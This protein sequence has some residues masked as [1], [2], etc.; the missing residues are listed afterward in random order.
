MT[1]TRYITRPIKWI[2]QP[3]SEPIFCEAA[4]TIEITDEAGGEFVVIAQQTDQHANQRIAVS[5]E[6]WPLIRDAIESAISLCEDR[7]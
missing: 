5:R 6:H 2:V 7:E 1:T 4:T 3:V